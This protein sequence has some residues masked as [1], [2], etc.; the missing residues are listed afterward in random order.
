MQYLG[1][2]INSLAVFLVY[3]HNYSG[4]RELSWADID[5]SAAA[6]TSIPLVLMADLSV[7]MARVENF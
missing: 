1:S 6:D 3:G 5:D 7:V 4:Q 2:L